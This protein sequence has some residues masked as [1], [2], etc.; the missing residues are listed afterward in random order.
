MAGRGEPRPYKEESI[1][2]E[3]GICRE[4]GVRGEDKAARLLIAEGLDGV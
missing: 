2:R 4:Y 3:E 1:R